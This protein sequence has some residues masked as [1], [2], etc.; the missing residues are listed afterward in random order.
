MTIKV[1]TTWAVKDGVLPISASDLEAAGGWSASLKPPRPV[2]VLCP[3]GQWHALTEFDEL[4]RHG[5]ITGWTLVAADSNS[6][7]ILND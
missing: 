7:T 3:D 1:K 4:K 6:W 5:E 2:Q